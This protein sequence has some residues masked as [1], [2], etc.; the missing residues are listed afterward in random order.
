MARRIA[1][2]GG[3]FDPVHH[4][5]LIAA[6]DAMEAVGA[7]E[8]ILMPA[9]A[10]PLRTEAPRATFAQRVEMLGLAVAGEP[11][12]RVSIIE[13]Q[14]PAPSDTCDTVDELGRAEPGAEIHWIIGGDQLARL[15]Q[16][17]DIGRLC[18]KVVFVCAERPGSTAEAPAI[19]GLRCVRVPARP[20]DIS[21]TE[22]RGRIAAGKSA[23][24]MTPASVLDYIARNSLYRN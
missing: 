8:V 21:S 4:G 11:G 12:M 3:T 10:A 13:G 24:W 20:V 5:H 17:R 2:L 15:P 14:R 23:R 18:G 16:W 7:E 9:N 22:I 19:D 6:R 1:V